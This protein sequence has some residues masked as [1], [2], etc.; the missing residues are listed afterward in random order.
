MN[1]LFATMQVII[2]IACALATVA[3]AG[4]GIDWIVEGY[5][6]NPWLAF[7]IAIAALLIGWAVLGAF[8][9]D[10]LFER[11]E[12]RLEAF[13]REAKQHRDE[14]LARIQQARSMQ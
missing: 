4:L 11:E 6:L 2:I 14:V 12:A 7:P 9:S 10:V 3:Y 5:G 8:I 1:K 13:R